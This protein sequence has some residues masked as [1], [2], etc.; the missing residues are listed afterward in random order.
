MKE[1]FNYITPEKAGISSKNVIKFM[2]ELEHYGVYLHGF[3]LVKGHDVFAE[4]YRAPFRKGEPHRLYSVSKTFTSM[5]MGCLIGEGKAKLTDTVISFFPEYDEK[6]TDPYVRNITIEDCL[7]MATAFSYGTT[8]SAKKPAYLEPDWVHTFFNVDASHPSGTVWNY[9][10][11]GSYMIGVIVEKVTGKP[12]IEYLKEKALLEIGCSN[13]I[14]CLKA[15][16]GYAWGGSAVLASTIDL[17]KF[18]R[19]VMDKGEWDGR[20]LLPG[21]YVEAA[22]SKKIDNGQEGFFTF[23]EGHGYGYQIWRTLDNTFSFLGMGGQ[24]AICMPDEDLLFVCNA[25]IQGLPGDYA[26][27]YMCLWKHIKELIGST[28][29]AEDRDSY[30]KLI[31]KC[32]NLEY[33]VFP[34]D[35]TSKVSEYIKG[36]KYV[37]NDNTMGIRDIIFDF[38]NDGNGVMKFTNEQG[39]KELRFGIGKTIIGEFPQDGYFGDTIGK[40]GNRRYRCIASGAWTTATTLHIKADVI[41]DYFG[42]VSIIA[43]FKGNEIGLYMQPH[44][45]WFML[46]YKGFAGGKINE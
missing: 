3:A 31:N 37:L 21:D 35:K 41:D 24:L 46:E 40:D 19:L 38:D 26:P 18:A 20:Q 1:F 8:Y 36:K 28:S 15:P 4:G 6:V 42:N 16:E 9:D 5:A 30:D 14:T 10:T 23:T 11:S 12:F 43:D 29:L 13:D 44:A 7:L 39:Y 32:S 45:E 22:I 17:A 25:D 33:P 27:I 34:G 2:D